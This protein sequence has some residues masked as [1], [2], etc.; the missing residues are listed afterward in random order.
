[1]QKKKGSTPKPKKAKKGKYLRDNKLISL[2]KKA[3]ANASIIEIRINGKT[4]IFYSSFVDPPATSENEEDEVPNAPPQKEVTPTGDHL[5]DTGRL[6]LKPLIPETGTKRAVTGNEALFRFY[7]GKKAV[8]GKAQFLNP[9]EGEE[10][11]LIQMTLP[12]VL[13]VVSERR[14]FRVKVIPELDLR[15]IEPLEARVLEMSAQGLS[16]CFPLDMDPY[17]KDTVLDLKLKIP[18]TM[19]VQERLQLESGLTMER[20]DDE[21]VTFKGF[22]RSFKPLSGNDKIC[23]PGA[24]RCGIQLDISSAQRLLEIGE[25]YAFV[26]RECMRAKAE[27]KGD[28]AKIKKADPDQSEDGNALEQIW[29]RIS[30]AWL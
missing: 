29:N 26:E 4:Q 16:F 9:M 12:K 8:L 11:N 20:S 22:V 15:L 23:P 28:Q 1:M 2:L 5:E 14:Y 7:D 27:K 17:E 18:P 13:R 19:E 25:V 6:F 30:E 3:H 10:E 21:F 24:Q